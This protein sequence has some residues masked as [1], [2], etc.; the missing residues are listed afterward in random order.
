MTNLSE[1]LKPF[2][3][4]PN[5]QT[6]SISQEACYRSEGAIFSVCEEQQMEQDFQHAPSYCGVLV[7]AGR[8]SEAASQ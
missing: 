1:F 4:A 3:D 2:S 5:D 6:P 7:T 8:L